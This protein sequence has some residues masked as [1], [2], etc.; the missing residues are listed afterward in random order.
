MTRMMQLLATAVGLLFGVSAAANDAAYILLYHHVAEDTPASTSVTPEQFAVH[1]DYI[2]ENGYKVVPL[3]K[4]LTALK[5]GKK[6]R[7]R[8]LAITFDDAYPSVLEN[9]LPVLKHRKW[10][11]T[12]FVSTEDIDRN[13]ASYL[14]WD[15][16]R[17]LE[18]SRGAIANHG[19]R[20]QHMLNRE[21][22]ETD[23]E[24]RDRIK[25]DIEFA[26]SR[27]EAE[28]KK[29][30]RLFSY[31]YGEF[32]ASLVQLVGELGYLAVGQQSGPLGSASNPL[33][34]PR[35]PQAIAYADL[36]RLAEKLN[37][38]PFNVIAPALPATVIA[39]DVE[40]PTLKLQVEAAPYRAGQ[41]TCFV[42]GIA[43]ARARWQ[44]PAATTVKVTARGELPPGRTHYTCTAPHES[45]PSLFYW[46]SHLFMKPMPDGSWYEN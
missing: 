29:P 45:I 23:A 2:S 42:S 31:P 24:W 43:T 9:A 35:F 10:P 44:D 37:T 36:P 39:P 18:K 6:I 11:F 15:Q 19:H 17:E 38:R 20:H 25:G 46:H 22:G 41:F 16:L 27:L 8:S 33:A 1:M 30:T 5:K 34:A 3:E 13:S 26:Q 7:R 21:P 12:V 40:R 28:L 4:L 32:D 14:N